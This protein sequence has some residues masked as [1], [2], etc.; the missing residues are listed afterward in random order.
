[1]GK[2]RAATKTPWRPGSARAK[3]S[4]ICSCAPLAWQKKRMAVIRMRWR[5]EV[6][7]QAPAKRANAPLPEP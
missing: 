6:E 5:T 7:V 4:W 3:V 2:R 1:M